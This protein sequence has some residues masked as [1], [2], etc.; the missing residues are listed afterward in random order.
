LAGPVVLI[1]IGVVFLLGTM[2]ILHLKTLALLFAHYWPVLIILWGVIK[3]VEHQQAQR[4]GQP[5]RGIGVGGVFLLA[6]LIAFGLIAS[7]AA[8]F[9]WEGLRDQMNIDDNEFPFFGHT[10]N[11]D[12]QMAQTFPA[13]ASLQ[14]TDDRGAVN[15][16]ISTDNQIHVTVH[17]RIS[18][19]T[20]QDADHWNSGT[21]PQISLNGLLM[22]LSA[23]TH[24]AGDHWVSTDMDISLPRK[25]SVV[26]SNHHGDVSVVG[27]DGDAEISGQHG[28]I[29][30]TDVNGKVTLHLEHS[31]ARIAQI[32]S[33]VSIEGHATDVSIEDVKGEVH[34]NGDFTE[35]LKL[36]KIAKPV[37]F[38]TARTS[39]EFARLDGD[40]NLDSGDLQADAITGPLRLE[41][42][43]KD[44][45][46]GA[47]SGDVRLSDENGMV[48][49]RMTKPA[50]MQVENRQGNIEIYLPEKAA[51]QLDARAQNGEISSDFAGVKNA[52]SNDQATATGSVAGGGPTLVLNNQHGDIKILKG[53]PHSEG[54]S[55]QPP[56]MP[57]PPKAPVPPQPQVPEET[58][59]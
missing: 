51:F 44:I 30:A 34:L 11:Y 15:L 28:D 59:N 18:A 16:T 23:N 24:G 3:L 50:S 58:E 56:M 13:G 53:S 43:S 5:A 12:D 52:E 41:T 8:R 36:A 25:A 27:R 49:I 1:I 39:L 22:T 26:I 33:D 2:G 6:V 7:Q 19:E 29:S 20:Q 54:K 40:L 14:V 57:K 32:S 10:Y 45:R 48:E 37:S 47:V 4:G 46:L 35:N 42:R 9:N 17:K 31:S 21:K 38:K 55:P